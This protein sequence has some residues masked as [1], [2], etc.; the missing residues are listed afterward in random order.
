MTNETT[1]R[2]AGRV[3]TKK[4]TSIPNCGSLMPNGSRLAHSSTVRHAPSEPEPASSPRTTG[5]AMTAR[6]RS[7]SMAW[8]Y[9]SSTCWAGVV[10]T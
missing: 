8:R 3:K 1:K 4:P 7:G 2:R 9:C 10:G 5:M 6:R